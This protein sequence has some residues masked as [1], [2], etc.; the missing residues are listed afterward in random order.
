MVR[1][2]AVTDLAVTLGLSEQAARHYVAQ[3][4]EL[5]D[6]LPRL[7][8]QVMAGR[9][10]VW[11]ARRVAEQTIPLKAATAGFVDAQLERVRP[12]A[13]PHPDQQMCRGGDH[14]LPARP[15]RTPR[16]SRC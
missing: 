8:A 7:W 14:P 15:R 12:P 11:K 3:T 10:P 1:E 16:R 13:L 6:R 9:L 5:R 4:V 2:F